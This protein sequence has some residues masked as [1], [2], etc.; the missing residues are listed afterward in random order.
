[1]KKEY[2]LIPQANK[3]LDIYFKL[4]VFNGY[5]LLIIY[6]MQS[7]YDYKEIAKMVHTNI[8]ALKEHIYSL[9]RW[10]EKVEVLF[11]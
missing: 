4:K 7:G 3:L 5:D 8:G 1:M 10:S 2:N 11:R 6:L 9:L